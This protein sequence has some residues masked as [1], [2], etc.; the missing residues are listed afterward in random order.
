MRGQLALNDVV[1]GW[2]NRELIVIFRYVYGMSYGLVRENSFLNSYN[3]EVEEVSFEIAGEL[4]HPDHADLRVGDSLVF[5][6]HIRNERIREVAERH[7][8]LPKFFIKNTISSILDSTG[9][10]VLV[11]DP[12]RTPSEVYLAAQAGLLQ[13]GMSDSAVRDL[14]DVIMR[15]QVGV[16]PQ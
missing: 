1:S 5:V 4:F 15:E 9:N 2:I 13:N 8:L 3:N 7:G 12:V 14:M 11:I 10:E 6:A 16:S